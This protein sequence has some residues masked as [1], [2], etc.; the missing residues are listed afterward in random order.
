[1]QIADL[2]VVIERTQ[3]DR[4]PATLMAF[5]GWDQDTWC[6]HAGLLKI[7][8][9][10]WLRRIHRFPYGGAMR[11]SKVVGQEPEILFKDWA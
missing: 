1:M 9:S 4:R 5:L 2:A 7:D 6:R 8:L 10:R 11:L 3:A